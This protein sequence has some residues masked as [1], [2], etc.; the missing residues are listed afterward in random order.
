[1]LE[2]TFKL[3]RREPTWK[4]VYRNLRLAILNR[5]LPPETRLIEVDLSQAMGVSRTPLREALAKLAQDGLIRSAERGGYVVTDPRQDLADAYHL[6]AAIEGYAARLAAEN[7]TN[8]EIQ[9]LRENVAANMAIDLSD[10]RRR[11]ELNLEFHQI[12]AHASRAPRI[13]QAF[14]NQ[15]EFIFTDEDMQIHTLDACRQFVREHEILV[16]ALE[17]RDGDKADR[18]VRAHLHRAVGLLLDNGRDAMSASKGKKS[19][20][21]EAA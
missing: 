15:R 8:A 9:R 2:E 1:M 21:A 3:P 16:D 18:I 11:A 12:V 14:D 6:R 13:I 7:I 4:G 20:D 10:T 5:S 17:L 19:S